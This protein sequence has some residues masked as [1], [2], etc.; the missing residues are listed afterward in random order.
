M[1]TTEIWTYRDTAWSGTALNGMDIEAK[2]GGIGKIEKATDSYIVVDV[3]PAPKKI[4]KSD[5]AQRTNGPSP[6][7]PMGS[8][9]THREIRDVVEYLTNLK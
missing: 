6:M 8:L 3:S 5:I 1:S 4:T 9:L 2:D 7:P